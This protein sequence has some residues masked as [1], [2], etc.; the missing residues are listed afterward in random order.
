MKTGEPEQE[1][2]GAE[3]ASHLVEGTIRTVLDELKGD[4]G[5]IADP[6]EPQRLDVYGDT[7]LGA[8]SL[9]VGDSKLVTAVSDVKVGKGAGVLGSRNHDSGCEEG[10]EPEKGNLRVP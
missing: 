5:P 2:K 1:N 3:D 10:G 7:A 8:L 6:R 4:V 9:E